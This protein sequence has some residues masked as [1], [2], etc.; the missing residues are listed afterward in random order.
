[1]VQIFFQIYAIH[2][3]VNHEV[4]PCV[5]ALLPSKTEIVY[6]QLFTTIC[7]AVRNNKGNNQDGFLVDFKTP[8]INAIQNVLPQT[9]M[10]GCIF[11]LL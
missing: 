10:S 6:K 2:A 1:M 9:N 11:H 3:L 5:F 8:A 4:F 7:N